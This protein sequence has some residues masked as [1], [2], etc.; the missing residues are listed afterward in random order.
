MTILK[1]KHNIQPLKVIGGFYC[2][3]TIKLIVVMK[4][5]VKG[6][7]LHNIS[8]DLYRGPRLHI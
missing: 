2:N 4:T 7:V 3:S 6:L 1:D 5:S 8:G